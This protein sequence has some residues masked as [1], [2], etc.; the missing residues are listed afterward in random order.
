[1]MDFSV[2]L[3]IGI[4]ILFAAVGANLSRIF[5]QPL[6]LGYVI[7][8]ILVGP[9]IFGFI[10]NTSLIATLSELGIAFLLFFVG[11]ELDLSKLKQVGLATAV[12]GVFEVIFITLIGAFLASHF[13]DPLTS[14]YVGLILAFSSTMIVLKLLADKRAIHSL[15]GRLILGILLVQDIL[16]VILLPLLASVGSTSVT[17]VIA[18]LL[19]V[20]VLLAAAYLLQKYVFKRLLKYISQQ[21]ELLF[22]TAIAICFAFMAVSY[23]WEFSI[24]IGGFLAGVA[25][26]APPYNT[27]IAGRVKSLKDFFLVLF[28]VTLGSQLTF[29]SFQAS[30]WFLMVGMI[31]IVL[32]IKPFVIFIFLKMFRYSNRSSLL[33]SISLAQVSEFSLIL[34][35][36]G[37]LAGH[38]PQEVFNIT[39][40]IAIAT[41]VFTGYIMKYDD[42][43]NHWFHDFLIPFEGLTSKK[44]L[45]FLPKYL[46]KHVVLFGADRMG[47][48]IIDALTSQKKNFI[49]ADYNPE[50]IRVLIKK[51]VHCIYGDYSNPEILDAL[52][53]DKAK[54]VISTIPSTE[55]NL[56]VLDV[57]KGLNPEVTVVVT[58]KTQTEAL[59][60]YNAGADFVVL[61][62]SL[63]GQKVGEYLKKLDKGQLKRRGSFY[64]KELKKQQRKGETQD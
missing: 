22:I 28:F 4:I 48:K 59:S 11:L 57:V 35:A 8:G 17:G 32:L 58:A 45:E 62:E 33:S 20:V 27:E 39:I 14:V 54:K 63:A 64:M 7:A 18:V 41:I 21:T 61:P 24:A 43:V 16:I 56:V 30:H 46:D 31:L 10:Q 3:D 36:T 37:L 9:A 2:L 6:I 34:A 44:D 53:L 29:T 15:H 40:L 42:T 38:I 23:W 26:A 52:R 1:M 55:D 60:L 51:G 12:T 19:K 13:F 5:K 50:I 25:L 49:V 47:S